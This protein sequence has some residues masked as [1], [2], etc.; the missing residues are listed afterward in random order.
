MT[1]NNYDHN[2]DDIGNENDNGDDGHHSFVVGRCDVGWEVPSSRSGPTFLK[3]V[4][5]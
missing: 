3:R 1:K 4:P 5:K 2:H